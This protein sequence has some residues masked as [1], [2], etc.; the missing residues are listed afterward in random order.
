MIST[1]RNLDFRRR[2]REIYGEMSR[3]GVS[4]DLRAVVR[5]AIS[6]PAAAFYTDPVYAY[7]K[8]LLLRRDGTASLPPTPAGCMWMELLA[9][10]NAEVMR[11]GCSVSRALDYVLNF[12]HPS[13]FHISVGLGMRI[14]RAEFESR[15][16]HRPRR[17]L[18]ERSV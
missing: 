17:G 13:S 9:M 16:V 11:R 6:T 5:R 1:Q 18:T 2:C 14:A 7:N 4:P 12:R 8:I 10:V 3:Q 15:R